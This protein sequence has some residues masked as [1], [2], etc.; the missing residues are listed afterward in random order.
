[1]RVLRGVLRA[2]VARVG[3]PGMPAMEATLPA[4]LLFLARVAQL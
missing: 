4:G 1:M 2:M 3:T